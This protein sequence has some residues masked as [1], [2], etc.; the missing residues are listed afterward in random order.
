[1]KKKFLCLAFVAIVVTITGICFCG[2]AP[3]FKDIS[4]EEMNN[5]VFGADDIIQPRFITTSSVPYD[6][7]ELA[8]DHTVERGFPSSLYLIFIPKLLFSLEH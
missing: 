5:V 4:D 2:F 7:L 3:K 6:T 1:M 8:V